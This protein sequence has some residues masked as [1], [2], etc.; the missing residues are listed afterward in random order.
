MNSLP[1]SKPAKSKSAKSKS[2]KSKVLK[3]KVLKSLLSLL[4]SVLVLQASLPTKAQSLA[5]R[6]LAAKPAVVRIVTAC[7]GGVTYSNGESYVYSTGEVGTGFFISDNGYVATN[8]HVIQLADSDTNEAYCKQR[9]VRNLVEKIT[10]ESDLRNIP[11]DKRDQVN[12]TILEVE[13]LLEQG[14]ELEFFSKVILPNGD[15]RDFEVKEMGTPIGGDV[16]DIAVIKVE[17]SD[18]PTLQFYDAKAAPIG[19]RDT[20]T[21]IGY[22]VA[23]DVQDSSEFFEEF[24][25]GEGQSKKSTQLSLGQATVSGGEIS[26]P[27]KTLESGIEVIQLDALVSGG[28]SGSPVLNEAGKVVGIVTFEGVGF[29]SASSIPF[30]IPTETIL[31]FV[32][33]SGG[34]FNDP[35]ITDE[36]YAKGLAYRQKEDYT[37]AKLQFEA[38][39]S[40]FEPHSEASRLIEESDRIIATNQ[41]NRTFK[42]WLIGLSGS[43]AALIL[44]GLLLNRKLRYATSPAADDLPEDPR[45]VPSEDFSNRQ[46]ADVRSPLLTQPNMWA[47]VTQY[48]RPRT[49]VNKQP[50]ITLENPTHEAIE[51]LLVKDEHHIGRD[52]DWSDL[53]IPEE[54]W[55]VISRHHATLKRE[56][57]N[58]AIYDGD[59]KTGSTNKTFVNGEPVPVNRGIPLNDGDELVIGQEPEQQVRMTYSKTVQGKRQHRSSQLDRAHL[60]GASRNGSHH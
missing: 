15:T 28:S 10:G 50:C 3:S 24:F 31:E 21:I 4:P 8:S 59:G 54:G 7:K 52:P 9:L 41:S 58:Y 29:G 30:A 2:A 51:F 23:A 22:P 16:K 43:L 44:A 56:G 40:H 57:D 19:L 20:V 17:I 32:R 14:D 45:L 26:N 39:R 55:E 60:N 12:S 36:L 33:R 49:E 48:F 38:V 34:T 1:Y 13:N 11:L 53:K 25:S 27:F 47:N 37:N 35:S 6:S 46:Y 5:D 42:P 18:A